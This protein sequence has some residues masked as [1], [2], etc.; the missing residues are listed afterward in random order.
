M[1]TAQSKANT[2]VFSDLL[3]L[4]LDEAL[5]QSQERQPRWS[6]I[7]PMCLTT[8]AGELIPAMVLNLSASGL[9]ALVEASACVAASVQRGARLQGRFFFD[10][11]D[12]QDI[13][14]EVA[15]VEARGEQLIGL[16]CKF[17]NPPMNL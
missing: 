10:A 9:L 12:V 1:A 16:G 11:L 17:V 8:S 5:R 3:S 6:L 13:E 15:R 7:L 2:V 14:L 4:G